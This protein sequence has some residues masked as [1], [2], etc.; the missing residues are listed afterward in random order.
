MLSCS[1]VTVGSVHNLNNPVTDTLDVVLK[2]QSSK[3]GRSYC[4]S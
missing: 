1:A 2:P 4:G 3:Q